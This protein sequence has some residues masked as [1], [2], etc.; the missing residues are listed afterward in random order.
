MRVLLDAHALLWFIWG[1][2]N[3]SAKAQAI[4]A[5]GS[6]DLLL[7]AGTLW[8]IAIKVGLGKLQIAE[9]YEVFMDKAILDK[10]MGMAYFLNHAVD[11]LPQALVLTSI[12][13]S[14]GVLA[15]MAAICIRLYERYGTFDIN[16]MRRLKG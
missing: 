14:L 13:I 16:E 6:N 10:D 8:E 3:L 12:V 4:M 15:L 11:P 2:G 5:D 7:S 9:P 1:H